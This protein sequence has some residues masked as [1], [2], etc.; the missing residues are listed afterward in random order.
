MRPTLSSGRNRTIG[1]YNTAAFNVLPFNARRLIGPADVTVTS[2]DIFKR[3]MT[4]NFYKG[5]GM[6]FSA[7]WLKRRVVRFLTG[8][9]GSAPNVDETYNVSVTFGGGIVS[10]RL[11]VGTRTVL[12]GAL[13]NRHGFNRVPFN[14]LL[15]KFIP[16][17]VQYPLASVLKEAVES[18]ALELPFQ[19]HFVVSL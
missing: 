6:V 8:V 2:D 15:T 9:D 4:W 13:F 16:G 1:P 12:G 5:D 3:I 11:A 10:I 19:Y 18:G 17:P 14:S 7:R